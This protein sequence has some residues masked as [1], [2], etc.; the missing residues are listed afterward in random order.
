MDLVTHKR[1]IIQSGSKIAH[2]Q[3]IH[4]NSSI[5]YSQMLFFD[6]LEK[7]TNVKEKG[8][9]FLKVAGNGLDWATYKRGLARIAKASLEHYQDGNGD[10]AT[11]VAYAL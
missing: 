7:N 2:F 3:K 5:A 4:K 6:G 8:V 9:T 1:F 10:W 11:Y